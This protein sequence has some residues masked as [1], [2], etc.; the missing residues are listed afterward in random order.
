MI[1]VTKSTKVDEELLQKNIKEVLASGQFTNFGAKYRELTKRLEEYLGVK[2]LLLVTNGTVALELAYKLLN[3]KHAITTP[4]SF[5]ATTSSLAFNSIK[6]DFADIDSKTFNINLQNIEER[7]KNDPSIDSIVVVNVFGNANNFEEL[8]SL[9]TKYSLKLIVDAAHSFNTFYKN[10]SVLNYGDISTI[11]FHATKLFSTT[12][13]GALVIKDDNLFKEAK[14]MVNFGMDG[15]NINSVGVNA[16][17]SELHCA[18]GLSVL[19]NVS[20]EIEKREIIY[21]Y[22]KQNLEG[23]VKFQTLNKD[24]TK[25]NY[26]YMP[27]V[28]KNETELLKVVEE[29]NKKDIFAR[30]YF[31]PSLNRLK[32]L[33]EHKNM[34]NSESLSSKILCLPLYSELD[35]KDIDNIINIIKENI[36]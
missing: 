33:K 10:S 36:N 8:E 13:G 27:V 4:F 16:K 25:Y 34:P 17:L 18:F 12:E 5:V 7:V 28:F 31:Y 35:F 2:N 11:S 22:Y 15:K 6:I 29:L 14:E 32:Y 19:S 26:S 30:R 23:S 3:I 9:A 24:L 1:N 20:K 21:N